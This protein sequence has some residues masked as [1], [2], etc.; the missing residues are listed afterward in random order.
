MVSLAHE[1]HPLRVHLQVRD[2]QE[3]S[4]AACFSSATD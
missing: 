2:G 4:Q 3:R 1:A